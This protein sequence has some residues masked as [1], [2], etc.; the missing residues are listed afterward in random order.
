M[1]V[2]DKPWISLEVFALS[3]PALRS[4]RVSISL[5]GNVLSAVW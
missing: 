4:A 3:A 5:P 1:A 2:F